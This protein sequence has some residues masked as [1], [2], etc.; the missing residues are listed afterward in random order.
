MWDNN[1]CPRDNPPVSL[2]FFYGFS[3]TCQFFYAGTGTG[4]NFHLQAVVMCRN[5][6]KGLTLS[7]CTAGLYTQI[8]VN[9]VREEDEK[10]Y[11]RENESDAI[12]CS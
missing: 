1:C 8:F 5:P 12:I 10:T 7:P 11:K 9:K 2:Q 6:R 3:G 4:G